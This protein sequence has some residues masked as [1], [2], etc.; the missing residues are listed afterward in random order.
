MI[1][2]TKEN[3]ENV[4][5]KSTHPIVIDIW[6]PWCQPCKIIAPLFEELSSEYQNIE[7]A[8]CN[9]D[10][11]P[12]I[13]SKFNI[14]GIPTVLYFNKGELLEVQVGAVS[15][16]TFVNKLNKLYENI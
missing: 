15:K 2:I 12:E 14:R 16:S 6:A 10:E 4:V 13:A 5:L 1:E 8:K 3:F 11:N 7:F 9:I